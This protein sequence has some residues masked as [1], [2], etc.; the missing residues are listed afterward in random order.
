M[1]DDWGRVAAALND[2]IAELK[3]TKAEVQDRAGVSQKTLDRY[4]AGEP[5][6]RP[7]KARGICKAL[8]WSSR[9]IDLLRAGGEAE[10]LGEP[11]SDRDYDDRL[12]RVEE[13]VAE[14][15]RLLQERGIGRGGNGRA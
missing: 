14:I 13:S 2:R 5:I 15:L 9:S 8:G 12:T 10:V 4:L 11:G 7:D 1:A 3:L 6:V